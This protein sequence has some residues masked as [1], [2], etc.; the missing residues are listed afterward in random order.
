MSDRVRH[1]LVKSSVQWNTLQE[2]LS[3]KVVLFVWRGVGS[4]YRLPFS[5]LQ[6]EE[7]GGRRRLTLQQIHK[8]RSRDHTELSRSESEKAVPGVTE[9]AS[10][11][12]GH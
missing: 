3:L 11:K 5:P 1:R 7:K 8:S 6:H 4:G 9:I 2:T 10:M 12:P